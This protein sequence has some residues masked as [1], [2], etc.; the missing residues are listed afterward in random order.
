MIPL[1]SPHQGRRYSQKDQ[2]NQRDVRSFGRSVGPP[3]S[4]E[5]P[6]KE[7]Q[8]QYQH[9]AEILGHYL[10]D[11]GRIIHQDIYT[12]DIDTFIRVRLRFRKPF[13]IKGVRRTRANRSER[14]ISFR[15]PS[16][17][18]LDG[19]VDRLQMRLNTR[20]TAATG[21]ANEIPWSP[22]SGS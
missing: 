22:S 15:N 7:G 5:V 3:M 12:V 11:G 19:V 10:Q 2:A 4:V 17:P 13:L 9:A 6:A 16:T 1:L 14:P 20:A 21:V 8:Y 18:T